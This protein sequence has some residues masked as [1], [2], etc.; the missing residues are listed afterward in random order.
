MP[1]KMMLQPPACA[2]GEE[3]T[4]LG[5]EA[6]CA[7]SC[8]QHPSPCEGL[9]S[10]RSFPTAV[11]PL[12][13]RPGWHL[14]HGRGCL[15]LPQCLA[16]LSAHHTEWV[17]QGVEKGHVQAQGEGATKGTPSLG[18][19]SHTLTKAFSLSLSCKSNKLLVFPARRKGD[20]GTC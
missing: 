16:Q 10:S 17:L 4:G 7:S 11:P 20:R 9:P 8:P 12:T 18:G 1:L 2:P 13:T 14:P 5:G 6:A 19:A 3:G 15:S